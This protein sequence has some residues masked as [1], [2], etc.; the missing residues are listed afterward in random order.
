V[1]VTERQRH[2]LFKRFEETLGPEHAATMM[3]LLPPVGWAD[4]ATKHDLDAMRAATK[5]DIDAM[6]AATKQDIDAMRAATKQDIDAM[7]AA[8][9]Q[10][11]DAMGAA[12]KHD[13]DAL[14]IDVDAL[15]AATKHDLDGLEHRLE[16]RLTRSFMTW[17]LTGMG[18]QTAVVGLLV[19][20][21]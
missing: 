15:R 19:G 5:Q 18:I 9:K 8:T 2:D 10:D 16:A 11:I 13:I 4:V 21:S 6:R 12:T 20:L 7:R 3:E 14:R 17:L 1:S